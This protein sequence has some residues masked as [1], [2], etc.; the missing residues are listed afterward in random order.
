MSIPVERDD[1][2]VRFASDHFQLRSTGVD[3]KYLE[4]VAAPLGKWQDI[5]P[6]EE[7]LDKGVFDTTLSRY[8]EKIPLMVNHE[9]HKLAVAMPV[10]WRKS[11][12]ALTGVWK[13]DTRQE[14][15]EIHRMAEDGLLTSLSVHFAPGKKKGDNVVDT[16]GDRH[17]VT[18]MQAR[19]LEVSLV[20]VPA[21]E[22][23]RVSLVRTAGLS[24]IEEL[25]AQDHTPRADEM[26]ARFAELQ[27]RLTKIG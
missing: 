6:Y 19:L 16:D 25:V 1:E 12:E 17:R 8:S 3:G 2:Q 27:E 18:R 24:E 20:S 4:G 26:R 13:F 11:D 23:A 9:I 21:Y 7:R 15:V 14:A 10:K 22:D 5:G